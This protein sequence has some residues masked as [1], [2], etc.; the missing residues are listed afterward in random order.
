MNNENFDNQ[1]TNTAENSQDFTPDWGFEQNQPA[2]IDEKTSE[3]E[4][5]AKTSMIL[6]IIGLVLVITCCGIVG[7]VLNIISLVMASS[8]KKALGYEH[9]D[10]TV[11]KIC[12]IVGLVISALSIIA[13][14]LY[15]V[16]A[17]IVAMAAAGV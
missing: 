11:G 16:F 10:A 14:V 5:K 3:A 15:L 7:I 9:S 13:C 8:S 12:S 4:K 2:V 17:I 6:G 1:N